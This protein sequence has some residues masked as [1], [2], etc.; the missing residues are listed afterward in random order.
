MLSTS[1]L[2]T[3]HTARI[4]GLSLIWFLRFRIFATSDFG[5]LDGWTFRSSENTMVYATNVQ[6]RPVDIYMLAVAKEKKYLSV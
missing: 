4:A 6:I 2:T 1:L 3:Q 5:F